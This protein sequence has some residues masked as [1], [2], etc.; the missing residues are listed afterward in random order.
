[1][2]YLRGAD[3]HTWFGVALHFLGHI[4]RHL[5]VLQGKKHLVESLMINSMV[6]GLGFRKEARASELALGSFLQQLLAD[7][8]INL[9]LASIFSFFKK[10]FQ[11][12]IFPAKQSSTHSTKHKHQLIE[13]YENLD[14]WRFAGWK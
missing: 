14:I 8:P 4:S 10:Y 11:I 13:I 5:E 9:T 7:N 3:L 1:M 2:E 12:A 6:L